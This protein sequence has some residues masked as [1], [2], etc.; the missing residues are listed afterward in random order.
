MPVVRGGGAAWE[1]RVS[2]TSTTR[3]FWREPFEVARLRTSAL[4]SG[5]LTW[6]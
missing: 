1:V 2:A 5:L 6:P 3:G 4:A